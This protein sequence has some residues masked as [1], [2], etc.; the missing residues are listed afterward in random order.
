MG[1]REDKGEKVMDEKKKTEMELLSDRLLR[2]KKSVFYTNR[3]SY[4][5]SKD[6]CDRYI[7]YLNLCKTERECVEE[8][9]KILGSHGFNDFSAADPLLSGQKVILNVKGK[10]LI[11]AVGGSEN[12]SEG[13]RIVAA[14]IDSPRLDLK[15][16]PLYETKGFGYLKTHYYGGIKKYQW[17]A[18]PLA[19]HGVV[20]TKDGT[21]IKVSVGEAEGEPVF[22]ITDLLPHLSRN[23]QDKRTAREVIKGEELN[24]LIG[25]MPVKDESVKEPIKL[26]LMKLLNE[27]YDIVE[28]DFISAEIEFV[29]NYKAGYV[30]FDES[31]I[32]GYAQDDRVC[33]YAAVEAISKLE[34]PK[35]T[36]VLVL[37]DKEE[38]G[39]DGNTG[40]AS[41][42]LRNFV[43]LISKRAGVDAETVLA[44]SKCISADVTNGYDPTF[45]EVSEPHN[46]A[47]L[48]HG[49]SLE[50]YT[51]AAGKSNTSEAS[52][53]Y[54]AE[55]RALLD[56]ADIPWQANEIGKI[57]E[58]GGGTV[59]KFIAR[60]GVDVI[61]MGV[62]VL[63]MHA[64]YEITSR[65]DCFYLY[66]LFKEFFM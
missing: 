7:T 54:V 36:T 45:A 48:N 56:G 12:L 15:P 10:S 52:A 58:G 20:I 27:R 66:R 11:A 22:S 64:P 5:L 35:Y 50:R 31:F 17:V 39:S 34:R 25:S 9:I 14:H 49:V 29:P 32:G 26:Y 61:D 38:T 59:A 24:V 43:S 13:L 47:Y 30:G 6:Y 28:E 21:S 53:E 23:V 42:M 55:I 16:H 33:A 44:H 18:I 62:P 57:D 63:S 40:L 60:L 51:G 2:R 8:S 65:I 46:A 1:F 19:M 3:D 37:A 4:E 41:D